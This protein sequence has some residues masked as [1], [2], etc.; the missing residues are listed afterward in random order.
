MGNTKSSHTNHDQSSTTKLT[1]QKWQD[2]DQFLILFHRVGAYLFSGREGK[3]S[4]SHK[5]Y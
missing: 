3:D 5:A 2:G 1:T 4:N